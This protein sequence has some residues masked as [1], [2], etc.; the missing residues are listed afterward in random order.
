MARKET[1]L[2]YLKEFEKSEAKLQ[3]KEKLEVLNLM[4]D[5][6]IG[7]GEGQ[8]TGTGDFNFVDDKMKK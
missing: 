8:T 3:E 7:A 1:A 6:T 4:P 5:Q 2:A